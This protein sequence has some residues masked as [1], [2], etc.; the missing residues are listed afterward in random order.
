MSID[1]TDKDKIEK[2]KKKLFDNDI[3][4]L[5]KEHRG[6]MHEIPV[7]AEK[8]WKHDDLKPRDNTP[9]IIM[10]PTIFKKF[11]IGSLIFLVVAAL[12]A[13]YS[14]FGQTHVASNS[15]VNLEI[16]GN[17][18]SPG[19]EE[20]PLQVVATNN[21]TTDIEYASLLLEY[22]KGSEDI[23]NGALE[24]KSTDIGTIES[25]KSFSYDA[26]VV[27]YGEQGATRLVKA[28]LEY[29]L[30]NSNAILQ[31]F[32]EFTVQISSAPLDIAVEGS[33][34]TS[35]NQE[36]SFDIISTLKVEKPAQNMI[37][38]VEYPP[39]F[40]FSEASPKP[41]L[42]NNVWDLGDLAQGVPKK[43]TVTGSL[44]APE[45]EERAFRIFAG[46]KSEEDESVVG[47]AFNS[48]IHTIKINRPFIQAHLA[49]NGVDTPPYVVKAGSDIDVNI[50]W[51]NNLPTRVDN[52]EISAHI[53]GNAF[54]D[55]AIKNEDGFYDS[56]LDKIVWDTS[57]TPSFTSIE[58]GENG[59][60]SFSIKPKYVASGSPQVLIEVS[61]KGRQPNGSGLSEVNNFEKA[62]VRVAS[63]FQISAGASYGT[64]PFANT[65]SMPPKAESQTTYGIH[66]SLT[67]SSNRISGAVAKTTLPSYV[68]WTGVVYPNTEDVKYD[69]ATN[70]ITWK[71][72][73][74]APGTGFGSVEKS[75]W[76]QVEL[77]PSKSQVGST[78]ILIDKTSLTGQD[79]FIGAS[80][81]PAPRSAVTT[82][83]TED[84]T[85]V[86]GNEKVVE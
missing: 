74:V 82:R 45:G 8:E 24:R 67:N 48:L 52:V 17:G 51:A 40:K 13:A 31:K 46:I 3:S 33:T 10:K 16:V 63:D 57:T 19:G 66:W 1:V 55:T 85:F 69:S 61:I 28:T 29:R 42:G 73:A 58:P 50:D 2:L 37:V 47:V 22:P 15:N 84:S 49:I 26:R 53:S 60:L 21:N 36:F 83:L 35:P 27:L 43:I 68:K 39:G 11:F 6:V 59:R 81:S 34:D 25:G 20:L 18:F 7:E 86:Q 71:I 5:R 32:A 80:L 23:E 70:E 12:F 79:T 41:A 30:K 44:I 77:K 9:S 64:A 62:E 54:D 14:F 38:K 72:G 75:V 4:K 76:F 56:A 78:A 65:G